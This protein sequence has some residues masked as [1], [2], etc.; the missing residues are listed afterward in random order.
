M[1]YF[2]QFAYVSRCELNNI[3]FTGSITNCI[4]FT[5]RWKYSLWY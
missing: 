5:T 1:Q 2:L 3:T 4:L